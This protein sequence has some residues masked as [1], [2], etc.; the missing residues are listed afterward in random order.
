MF[1]VYDESRNITALH[2]Y[3]HEYIYIINANS[4]KVKDIL[5]A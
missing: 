4:S 5:L 1:C 2:A 3:I